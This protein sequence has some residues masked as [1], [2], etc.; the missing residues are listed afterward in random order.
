MVRLAA[1]VSAR[2]RC[3]ALIEEKGAA[4]PE[5]RAAVEALGAARGMG[6]DASKAEVEALLRAYPL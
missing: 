4:V 3:W 5:I 6:P 1:R 2:Q